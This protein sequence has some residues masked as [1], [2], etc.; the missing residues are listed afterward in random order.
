MMGSY[1]SEKAA[2]QKEHE[3]ISGELEA[4]RDVEQDISAWLELVAE[5]EQ[6]DTL[7]RG[8]VLKLIESVEVQETFDA[9]GKRHLEIW[10]NYRFIGRLTQKTE[11]NAPHGVPLGSI[12]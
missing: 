4:Y 10:V 8:I 1:T 3:E 2:L 6:I 5:H 7:D 11:R 12:A 9:D